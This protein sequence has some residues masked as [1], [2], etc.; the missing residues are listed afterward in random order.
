ME[1]DAS[2]EVSKQK[3]VA[4]FLAPKASEYIR[5]RLEAKKLS[6]QEIVDF[7][8]KMFRTAYQFA[9]SSHRPPYASLHLGRVIR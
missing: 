7:H 4:R 6:G 3:Q 5:E 8:Q 2:G 9:G 1:V